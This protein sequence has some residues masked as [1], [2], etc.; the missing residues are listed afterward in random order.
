M[1]I[2]GISGLAN[3]LSFKEKHWPSLDSRDYRIAQGYDAAAAL[4]SRGRLTGAAAEERFSRCKHTGEFPIGAASYCLAERGIGIHEVDEI[5]HGFDYSAYRELYSMDPVSSELYRSVF[6]RE[7]LLDQIDRHFPGFPHDRVH[8]VGHH[9][10]HAASAY[11]TSG[12]DECLVVVID[13]MGEVQSATIYRGSAGRLEKLRE[14]SAGHSI[15]ILYSLVTLHLGF[16]FNSDEYKIMGLAPYGD[17]KRYERFFREAVKLQDDGTIRIPILGM[18]RARDDRENYTATRRYLEENLI[19]A[20][21]PERDLTDEHRDV[22]AA[23]QDCL[24]QVVL[25]I[26]GHFR[27]LTGLRRLAL[28]GGVALN[29]TA[30]GKLVRSGLFDEV[31]VQPVAGDDGVAYGAALYRASLGNEVVN[32]RSPAP[33]YGPSY[34]TKQI[35]AALEEFRDRLEVTRF[36]TLHET[37]GDA[38]ALIS[39]GK[40]IAWHRGRM[41]YGPRA[42][43]NRSILADPGRPE[44]RDRINAMVK[45]REAF[46][47]FAPAVSLEQVH[48]WFDVAPMTEMPYMITTVDVR[49]GRRG[50]LPAITHVNGSARVQTVS[51]VDNPAFHMLLQAVG[52][53]SGREMVLNT[54]F[55]VKGQPIVNTPSEAIA[56]FLGTGIDFLFLEDFRVSRKRVV[57]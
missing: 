36:G 49:E 43:G 38:A 12:W 4:V 18:N 42:L 7:V 40:V 55:N 19:P 6:S 15:G 16:D 27:T 8:Q 24:E 29:C 45:K 50:E 21:P 48:E 47:P 9:L 39:Q 44:M 30:N 34:S 11:F 3:A 46:R 1:N 28:A 14:I 5:A 35:E 25:H 31:Y 52:T 13:A 32:A 57:R 41:E 37:C 22:A 53:V 10:A 56:T 2:L 20:R 51:S 23:L 26:C 54:S 33:L 17:P